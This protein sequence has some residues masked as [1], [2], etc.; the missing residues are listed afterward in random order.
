VIW[1]KDPTR[2]SIFTVA[3]S[4]KMVSK[5]S[6][7]APSTVDKA[8]PLSMRVS[9]LN[10][11]RAA[12]EN[13]IKLP[14]SA[15]TEEKSGRSSVREGKRSIPSST[16]RAA[17]AFMPKRLGPAMGL[18]RVCCNKEPERESA[19]PHRSAEAIR[20]MRRCMIM[21]RLPPFVRLD[22]NP[23]SNSSGERPTAPLQSEK[24]APAKARA[25]SPVSFPLEE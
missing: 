10:R 24:H 5:A 4:G 22:I 17:D 20:T 13:T 6:L 23:E 3:R 11:Y 19:L 9:R 14:T 25:N 1:E 7:I 2:K 15:P 16:E 12:R 8:I 18:F 21:E